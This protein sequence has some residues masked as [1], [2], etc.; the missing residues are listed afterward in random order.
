MIEK[1]KPKWKR[2]EEAVTSIQ[3]NIAPNAQISH[4]VK[5]KGKSGVDRQIDVA[6][7]YNIGQY[8]IL[9][10]V[11]CKDWKNPA[12]IGDVGQFIDMVEDVGA[13]KGALICN[14]GFTNGAKKRAKE[15]GIDLLRVIDTENPNIKLKIGIP[16]LCSFISLKTFNFSFRHSVPAP[17]SMPACD[18]RYIEIYKQDHSFNDILM[19]LLTKAWN[20]GKLPFEI[21]KHKG[22][23]FVEDD[24]YT[25]VDNVFYGPVEI[26]VGILVVRKL[27]FGTIPLEKAK[28]FAN[29]ITKGFTT[30]TIEFGVDVVEVEKKWQ[31]ISDPS[32]LSIQPTVTLHATDYFPLIEYKLPTKQSI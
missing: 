7:Q 29:E 30:N 23:K 5:M 8:N 10:I 13:N 9:V 24:A 4:D 12:D 20:S 1:K 15:K 31:E 11:D 21:G 6:I 32:E 19:N 17:F 28:G 26:T 18:P 16:A 25:K 14:A 3:K 27:F 22:L 2:F